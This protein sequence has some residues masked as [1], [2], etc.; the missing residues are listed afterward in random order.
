MD[1]PVVTLSTLLAEFNIA[2]LIYE[3][4]ASPSLCVLETERFRVHG[5][6]DIV[7]L[8]RMYLHQPRAVS[9]CY[10]DVGT[11]WILWRGDETLYYGPDGYPRSKC[12]EVHPP[13]GYVSC[14]LQ[15][16][17]R[18]YALG[19]IFIVY[20]WDDRNESHYADGTVTRQNGGDYLFQ[21]EPN[22]RL[23]EM[24]SQPSYGIG[25]HGCWFTQQ[26]VSLREHNREL[27]GLSEHGIIVPMQALRGRGI[28]WSVLRGK[29]PEFIATIRDAMRLKKMVKH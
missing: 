26:F 2:H 15:F 18:Q 10:D 13:H 27:Y 28:S 23:R 12:T 21:M 8:I 22:S 24:Y 6:R 7:E 29:N 5:M 9:F 16:S 14:E 25:S 20:Q 4:S 3:Y 1:S 19:S 17:T 11:P